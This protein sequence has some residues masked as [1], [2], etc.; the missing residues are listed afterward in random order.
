[1]RTRIILISA[2]ATLALVAVIAL[3][4]G[5]SDDDTATGTVN[6]V[7]AAFYPVAF[8]AQ[9]VGG[10]TVRVKNLTPPGVEPHDL[11]A[12]PEDVTELESADVDLLMGHDFQPALEQAAD[13]GGS[14][15][16]DLLD[17]PGLDLR[18]DDP[19]VWLDPIR[20]ERLV[21]RIAEALG[22][23]AAVRPMIERL[24]AL[25]AAYKR[26]LAHC[27]RSEIVT[28]HEA[29]GYLA[30]RYGLRQV[31]ITGLSPEAEPSP[32]HLADV[33]DRVRSS[34]ATTVYGETLLSPKL[35]DTVARETGAR[36]AVLN[37]IE[38]LTPAEASRGEDYFSL[39]RE[40][41][42]ALR[43]GLGCR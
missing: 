10:P 26:G 24:N 17:T 30:E 13:Q 7:V 41:L 43:K 23:P 5:S 18:P 28:S 38:G 8:A 14:A 35:A 1:V 9:E 12:T 22:D 31:A 34:G 39:M 20:Y 11:E 25:D 21:R 37:P 33:I 27:R 6:D 32:A 36:T 40:N 29:F 2:L 19:H 42:A 16:V 4:G 15:V 3:T